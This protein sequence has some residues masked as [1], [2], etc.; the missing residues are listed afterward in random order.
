MKKSVKA[1]PFCSLL[2]WLIEN[3]STNM[4][5]LELTI[6]FQYSQKISPSDCDAGS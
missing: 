2:A 5:R 1:Q 4:I 6:N 3:E